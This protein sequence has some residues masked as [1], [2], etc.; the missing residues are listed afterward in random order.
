MAGMARTSALL[1][2]LA[3]LLLVPAA[4]GAATFTVD[5]TADADDTNLGDGVCFAGRAA[6]CT[7]RAAVEE[8]NE[9]GKPGTVNVP[10]GDYTLSLQTAIAIS[11]DVTIQ[12]AGARATRV[13]AEIDSTTGEGFDRVFD[14]TGL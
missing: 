4:A 12:G 10:A 3:A 8:I 11:E 13:Q 7:L 1:A 14:I 5:T 9:E 2:A 6:A